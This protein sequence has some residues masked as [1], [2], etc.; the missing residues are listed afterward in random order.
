M[1]KESLENAIAAALRAA[2]VRD[3]T[4]DEGDTA[5]RGTAGVEGRYGSLRDALAAAIAAWP[6][7]SALPSIRD[8]EVA[9]V[10]PIALSDAIDDGWAST[11][12]TLLQPGQGEEGQTGVYETKPWMLEPGSDAYPTATG[13][14]NVGADLAKALL[15]AAAG[16]GWAGS[17]ALLGALSGADSTVSGSAVLEGSVQQLVQ[18]MAGFSPQGAGQVAS[19]ALLPDLMASLIANP[20]V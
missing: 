7:A 9:Q 3:T 8:V 12:P 20:Q 18:A 1:D 15:G 19:G 16:A 14:A 5:A 2:R 10:K 6:Q 4:G 17:S 11:R 13:T